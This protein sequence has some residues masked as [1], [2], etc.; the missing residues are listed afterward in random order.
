MVTKSLTAGRATTVRVIDVEERE[1]A[2]PACGGEKGG[3]ADKREVYPSP[4]LGTKQCW[5]AKHRA[6]EP[7]PSR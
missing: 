4:G 3:D 1:V 6:S 7:G 2:S 5:V